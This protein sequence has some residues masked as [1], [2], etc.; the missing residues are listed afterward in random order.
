LIGFYGDPIQ[1]TNYNAAD[2]PAASIVH[3]FNTA[4]NS[5]KAANFAFEEDL[6]SLAR[7]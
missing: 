4:L 7:H 6:G 5:N 2:I 1:R 3:H